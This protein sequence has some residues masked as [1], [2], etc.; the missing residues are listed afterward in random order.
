MG[1]VLSKYLKQYFGFERFR[2]GQEE[3]ISSVLNYNDTLAVMPTGGGKSLCYQLPAILQKGTALVI[4]PLI[5]L[6]KDQVDTLNRRNLPS[7]FVNS[8][9]SYEEMLS[10]IENTI[11]GHY[12][13]LYIAP[14]RL[15]SKSFLNY[16]SKIEISFLAVDEAHCISEW[17][18]DFR[19]SYLKIADIKSIF[20]D[21]TIIALTATATPE[22]QEDIVKNLNM[23]NPK[24]FVKGFDRPN[25]S[26]MSIKTNDKISKIVDIITGTKTG[27]NIIYTATRRKAES[28]VVG[29]K[30]MKIDAL[31]Y[32]AGLNDNYRKYTQERFINGEVNTIVATNAFGMGIDKPDVRNVIHADFTQSLEAYY[33]EAGRAGRDGNE[34]KCYLLYRPD[35]RKIQEFFID[36]TYPDKK[37]IGFIYNY[38]YDLNNIEIGHRCFEPIP[39]DLDILANELHLPIATIKSVLKLFIR[40]K[41][42]ARTNELRTG[43]IKITTLRERIREFYDNISLKEKECLEGLLRGLPS[44][45]FD[46]YVQFDSDYLVRKYY[47]DVNEFDKLLRKMEDLNLLDLRSPDS[48]PAFYLTKDRT[49]IDNLPID[50]EEQK[51]RRDFAIKKLNIVQQYAETF[52]CKRNFILHY[53]G[54]NSIQS[55]CGKCTSCLM[56]KFSKVELQNRFYYLEKSIFAACLELNNSFGKSNI[57]DYLKGNSNSSIK[58]H[59]LAKGRYFGSCKDFTK[60]EIKFAIEKAI[61]ESKL[62]VSG[63]RYPT[64]SVNTDILDNL[65]DV[66]PLDVKLN[67]DEYNNFKE[68]RKKLAYK[69]RVSE[70]SIVKLKTLKLIATLKPKNLFEL[71]KIEGVTTEF[72]KNYGEYFL[73]PQL[74]KDNKSVLTE[75]QKKIIKILKMND[76]NFEELHKVMKVDKNELAVMIQ[77]ILLSGEK[78][79]IKHW[80]KGEDIETVLNLL[81]KTPQIQLRQL[82]NRYDLNYSYPELRVLLAY[83]RSELI[84]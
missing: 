32:H 26:Y 69:F 19:P 5:S 24:K 53:F 62:S 63:G 21:L 45:V 14:E 28:I 20:P 56:P 65:S 59:N 71:S 79:N 6:M 52:E 9:L 8:T 70:N 76:L 54:D 81:N 27:S 49:D 84:G 2:D 39:L 34:S 13:L 42:L 10:R 47:L 64:L 1:G 74:L 29:L 40:Y 44:N 50:F 7:T 48:N 15:E 66:K 46:D 82:R 31:L 67:S 38:L 25:L 41:I 83:C 75:A 30:E 23:R 18:H 37:I 11:N 36:S 80:F 22:V 78:M 51:Q 60:D 72:V 33:Q 43:Q 73:K 57:I 4:S 16:L 3:I 61:Y 12:K 17:G 77:E 35:D 55:D 68:I 58:K